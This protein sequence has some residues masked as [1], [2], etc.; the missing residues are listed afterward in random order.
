MASAKNYVSAA[1]TEAMSRTPVTT[2]S[3]QPYGC[4]VEYTKSGSE[5]AVRRQPYATRTIPNRGESM[6]RRRQAMVSNVRCLSFE[7]DSPALVQ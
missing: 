6:R 2:A 5:A 3:A 4:S 7:R 1:L